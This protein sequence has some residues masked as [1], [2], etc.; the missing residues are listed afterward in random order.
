MHFS[1]LD[2]V[3]LFIPLI[4][5]WNIT[6]S[7]FLPSILIVHA[8]MIICSSLNLWLF[9]YTHS[10]ILI[11]CLLYILCS[12]WNCNCWKF[13]SINEWL[14]DWC[15]RQPFQLLAIRFCS[16][17]MCCLYKR[18]LTILKLICRF[19]CIRPL[20][21]P[22]IWLE[23]F[24][25][26]LYS[27]KRACPILCYHSLEYLITILLASFWTYCIMY[28]AYILFFPGKDRHHVIARSP[29]WTHFL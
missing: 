7:N 26:Y 22:L 27:S 23:S 6:A 24:T 9:G 29:W 15:L 3:C 10:V 12:H 1:F 11:V 28:C 21:Y 16:L 4:F 20:Y 25:S 14:N 2:C 19:F 8:V 5:R 18:S 17:T 13:P